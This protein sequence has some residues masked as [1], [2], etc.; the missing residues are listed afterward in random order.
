MGPAPGALRTDRRTPSRS[1][2]LTTS[3]ENLVMVLPAQGG[4]CGSPRSCYGKLSCFLLA[5]AQAH[6]GDSMLHPRSPRRGGH[7][8]PPVWTAVDEA[9]VSLHGYRADFSAEPG[10]SHG[11]TQC[12]NPSST[13]ARTRPTQAPAPPSSAP[14][15]WHW[16]RPCLSFVQL[17]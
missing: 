2:P 5:C 8:S 4:G 11:P 10:Q 3:R 16:Q 12:F 13:S 15:E 7:Q 1:R 14:T 6:H 17:P 9:P